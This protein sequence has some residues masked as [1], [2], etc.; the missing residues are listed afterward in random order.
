MIG[1][2]NGILVGAIVGGSACAAV[3]I[4]ILMIIIIRLRRP[5]IT[6]ATTA[7]RVTGVDEIKIEIQEQCEEPIPTAVICPHPC[8]PLNIANTHEKPSMSQ[9]ES[10][11]VDGSQFQGDCNL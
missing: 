11:E 10:D 7:G 3:A 1:G 5:E 2:T 9:N 8:Y 6:N 4:L